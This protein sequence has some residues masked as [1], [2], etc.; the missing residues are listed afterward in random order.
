MTTPAPAQQTKTSARKGENTSG[1]SEKQKDVRLS[2]IIAAK[3]G[4]ETISIIEPTVFITRC[5]GHCTN[6]SWTQGD[7]QNGLFQLRF[8]PPFYNRI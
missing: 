2:N 8:Y 5:C 7:G 1:D 4:F 6:K 3:G